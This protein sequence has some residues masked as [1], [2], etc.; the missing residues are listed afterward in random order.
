[1]G[2]LDL[3]VLSN[4]FKR[5]KLIVYVSQN[6]DICGLKGQSEVLYWIIKAKNSLYSPCSSFSVFYSLVKLGFIIYHSRQ[7]SLRY[8]GPAIFGN[9]L[10][11]NYEGNKIQ[12]KQWQQYCSRSLNWYKKFGSAEAIF[13]TLSFVTDPTKAEPL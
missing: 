7:S 1:M 9:K 12:S 3:I 8:A 11:I 4:R 10:R 2:S 13:R 5:F 6:Y